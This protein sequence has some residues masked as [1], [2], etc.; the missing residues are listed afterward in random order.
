MQR[1]RAAHWR[2]P[3]PLVDPGRRRGRGAGG[4]R[5]AASRRR[6]RS[7][8]RPDA[9]QT[10]HRLGAADPARDDTGR[11]P[12]R[13]AR[14]RRD[15]TLKV[16]L[17]GGTGFL[18][19]NVARRLHAAGHELRVLARERSDLAGVP[20]AAEIVRGDVTDAGSL[21]RAAAGCGAV[22]HM[23]ALVKMWVPERER[24][25]AVNVEGLRH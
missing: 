8:G 12:E 4:P 6:A 2:D 5:S 25:D 20:E 9:A 10:R 7:R 16:L 1:P 15:G 22:V 24:F 3:R 13:L 23:A 21:V 17:T 14:S 19:K 18:G 11:P